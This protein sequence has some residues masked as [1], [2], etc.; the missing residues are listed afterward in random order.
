MWNGK[1]IVRWYGQLPFQA[2]IPSIIHNISLISDQSAVGGGFFNSP[3]QFG[4][5][6]TPNQAQKTVCT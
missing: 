5:A 3:G 4:A 6:T 2:K 1:P